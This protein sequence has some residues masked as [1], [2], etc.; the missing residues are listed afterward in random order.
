MAPLPN[1]AVELSSCV[2]PDLILLTKSRV[3]KWLYDIDES[4]FCLNQTLPNTISHK[5]K[6]S[7]IFRQQRLK[8]Y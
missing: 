2:C 5:W 1:S 8:L 4:Y 3:R 6:I 7:G